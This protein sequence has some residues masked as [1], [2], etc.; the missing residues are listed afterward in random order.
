[1]NQF[2]KL[3]EDAKPLDLIDAHCKA[4][5]MGDLST[6]PFDHFHE[7]A[8]LTLRLIEDD[9]DM[10]SM[11]LALVFMKIDLSTMRRLHND[12]TRFRPERSGAL[13]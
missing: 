7:L 8:E 2:R 1:M 10:A 12:M 11:Y 13:P 6:P 9:R 5:E 3:V 4:S